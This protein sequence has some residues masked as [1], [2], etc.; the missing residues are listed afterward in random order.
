MLLGHSSFG[1]EI[2]HNRDINYKSFDKY[3]NEKFRMQIINLNCYT[4]IL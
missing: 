3:C 1:D 4:H 2:D